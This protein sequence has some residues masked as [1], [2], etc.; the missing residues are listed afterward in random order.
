MNDAVAAVVWLAVN[1]LLVASAWRLS[2]RLFPRD[3]LG[4]TTI[5]VVTLCWGCIV[6]NVLVLGAL[7]ILSA[8]RLLASVSAT[9]VAALAV[10]WAAGP[11]APRA[12]L[13]GVCARQAAKGMRWWT[14]AWG[15][16]ASL[17]LARVA[18][19]G[20]WAFPSDWD[21][22]AYHVPLVDHWLRNGTLYVPACAFWYSPGNNEALGLWLV[23]PFSGD[24]LIALNNLPALILLASA[25]VELLS[26]FGVSPSLSHLAS[27]AIVATRATWR[28][29]V[30]AENDVAVAALFLAMLVYGLR[31][32][33]RGRRADLALASLAVGLLSGVKYYA[34]G[35]AGVAGLAVLSIVAVLRGWRVAARAAAVGLAGI[36]VLS[37]YWYLRNAWASGTPL[38][39]KGFTEATDTW[40]AIRP[41]SRTSTLL[42]SG[43]SEV[44][45]LLAFSV[46]THAGACQ[47][48]AALLLPATL[49]WLA[50]S[51]RQR[52]NGLARTRILRTWLVPL[53]V[54]SFLVF[55]NTPNVV[56]TVP[57]TMNMLRWQYHPVRFGL[58]PLSLAV[59]ALAVVAGDAAGS[60]TRAARRWATPWIA[61]TC[62]LG[63]WGVYGLFSACVVCQAAVHGRE[64]VALDHLLLAADIFIAGVLLALLTT[65]SSPFDRRVLHAVALCA[66]AAGV[67]GCHRLSV[68]WHRH[69]VQHYDTSY[70]HVPVLAQLSSLDASRERICICDDRY[71]PFFGSRRQFD[72]CRPLWVPDRARLR[73]YLRDHRITL[74]VARNHD[75][76]PRRRYASVRQWIAERPGPFQPFYE[77]GRF[78][79]VRVDRDRLRAMEQVGE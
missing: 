33:R 69:F 71:Y 70:F 50:L 1:S 8:G 67:L 30:S 34:L 64:D 11:R 32:A 60:L 72:V 45:P 76:S 36:V 44:W 58:C 15:M 79:I 21:T 77:D 13:G 42:G 28:Q 75:A 37:G 47:L 38:Y 46:A 24:F 52:R 54:L 10:A 17:L 53:T 2:R 16:L 18:L 61:A 62:R 59:V 5:H 14:I 9:C 7:G 41:D 31:Y 63:G 25:A 19:H 29:I 12:A 73:N 56:E 6:G 35:Y 78:T 74:L 57:G 3:G 26:A 40:S 39:P 48:A 55:L 65:S 49:L 22:L 4:E 27:M 20:L 43:R 68:R 23:A 66:V 51:A